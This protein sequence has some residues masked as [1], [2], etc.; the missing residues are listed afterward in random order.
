MNQFVDPLILM[1]TVR[2]EAHRRVAFLIAEKSMRR[3][4]VGLFAGVL[5][6]VPVARAMDLTK[7]GPGRIYLPD[8]KNDPLLVRGLNTDFES[9]DVQVGGLLVL[10]T[11]NGVSA[12]AEIIEVLSAE[13]LRLK[14]AFRGKDALKQLTGTDNIAPN[15]DLSNG[16]IGHRTSA[17]DEFAGTTY[18]IGPKVDQTKVY[19]EVFNRL[20]LGDCVGIFPEGGS[21]DRTELLPLKGLSLAYRLAIRRLTTRSIPQ[22]ALR[23][24]HWERSRRI[25]TAAS[26]L[27]PAA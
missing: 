4:F 11:I 10:P 16:V 1:R 12:N 6:A 2:L 3:R 5:G 7:P 20:N 15:G 22:L 21:H 17:G 24:W 25:Q 14:K 8:P 23:S 13:E 9:A 19:D 26:R 18:R 27:S